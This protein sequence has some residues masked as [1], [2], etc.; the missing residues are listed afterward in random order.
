MSKIKFSESERSVINKFYAWLSH[1]DTTP[2]MIR[3]IVEGTS[4]KR[5]NPS[6]P[7]SSEG[8]LLYD[9]EEILESRSLQEWEEMRSLDAT[10][11]GIKKDLV[12]PDFTAM[13]DALSKILL[14]IMDGANLGG[15]FAE[16][17]LYRRFIA[18]VWKLNPAIVALKMQD[19]NAPSLRDLAPILN[20][21]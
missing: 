6:R 12:E 17:M 4:A 9:A 19:G 21:T 14:W 15:E 2:E 11:D 1:K 16:R 7:E 20:T 5:G 18:T 10:L 3:E 8:E 13:S